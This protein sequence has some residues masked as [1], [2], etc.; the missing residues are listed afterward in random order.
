MMKRNAIGFWGAA[1]LFL[2]DDV[3]RLRLD[4]VATALILL[5]AAPLASALWNGLPVS[6]A[7]QASSLILA[8]LLVA[9]RGIRP[10]S[11]QGPGGSVEDRGSCQRRWIPCG[12]EP[13]R[14]RSDLFRS[15]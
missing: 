6:L 8:A 3:R 9:A 10:R 11:R 13:D 7:L 1:L 4:A 15:Y 2:A 12:G 14:D 5:L